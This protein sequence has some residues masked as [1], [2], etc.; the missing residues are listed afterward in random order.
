MISDPVKR[1]S[2]TGPC[3]IGWK[4]GLKRVVEQR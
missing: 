4:E 2:L 1:M 3:R